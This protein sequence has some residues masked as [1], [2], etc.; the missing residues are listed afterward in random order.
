MPMIA[1]RKSDLKEWAGEVYL[2]SSVL[3]FW[4]MEERVL[5]GLLIFLFLILMILVV[6]RNA[7]LGWIV[8]SLFLLFNLYMVLAMLDESLEFKTFS[9]AAA[10]LLL[11]GTLY[12]GTNIF[13][14]TYM[15]IKWGRKFG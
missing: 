1:I 7:I 10:E 12:L 4:V 15:L 5:N 14:S 8:S 6:T 13:V 9:K 3:F 2:I 11:G